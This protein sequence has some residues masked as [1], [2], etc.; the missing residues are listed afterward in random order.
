[1][2][3]RRGG[4]GVVWDTIVCAAEA[5]R[6]GV[7]CASTFHAF[8]LFDIFRSCAANHALTVSASIVLPR[9]PIKLT[10]V[11]A[12]LHPLPWFSLLSCSS[13]FQEAKHTCII[14]ICYCCLFCVPHLVRD[15][16]RWSTL[17]LWP[18]LA[19]ENGHGHDHG[20]TR[21]LQS[22]GT[23]QLGGISQQG[24]QRYPGLDVSSIKPIIGITA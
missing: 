19:A 10:K 8:F 5:H 18:T 9:T 22:T 14:T 13:T 4:T 1:M 15:S 11:W 16:Y 6:T 7:C 21:E 23:E 17:T 12:C 24:L 2:Q 3:H 20:L